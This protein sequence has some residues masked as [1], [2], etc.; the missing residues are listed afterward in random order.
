MLGIFP[1]GSLVR[2]ASDHL[3]VVIEAGEHP[4]APPRVRVFYSVKSN[5]HVF[6]RDIDLALVKDRIVGLESPRKWGFRDIEQVWM[7]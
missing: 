4:L 2:L 3:A 1:M 6:R 5:A 7:A